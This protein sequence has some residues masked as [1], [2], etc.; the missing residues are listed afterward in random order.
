MDVKK[1]K[2]MIKPPCPECPYKQG[3]IRTVKDPCPEC[4]MDGY[5]TYERFIKMAKGDQAE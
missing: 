1:I 2:H 5:K 4:K 3:I